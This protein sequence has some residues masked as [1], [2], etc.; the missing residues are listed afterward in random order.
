MN[1]TMI[2]NPSKIYEVIDVI[3]QRF[4]KDRKDNN[5]YGLLQDG[6]ALL[7]EVPNLINLSSEQETE[8]RKLEARLLDEEKDGKRNT[9]SYCEAQAKASDFYR[10]YRRAE[11]FKELCYDMVNMSKKLAGD[12]NKSFNTQ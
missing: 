7:E 11:N 2:Q 10:E 9:S 8:Y 3:T 4:R 5:Y 6:L 12:V 1:Q